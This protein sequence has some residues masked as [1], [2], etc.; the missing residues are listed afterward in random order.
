MNLEDFVATTLTQIAAGI[1]KAQDQAASTGAWINPAGGIRKD[2][3]M[4]VI[5]IDTNAFAYLEQVEFD[6]AVTAATDQTAHA[7]GGI[8]VMGLQLGAGGEANYLNSSVSRV[9]FSIPVSWPADRD[10][11]LEKRREEAARR[12]SE[13]RKQTTRNPYGAF[14]R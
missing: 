2:K 14:G 10:T 6:V 9:K 7:E 3:D 5:Q 12:T 8:K 4:A 11:D 13:A 1:A